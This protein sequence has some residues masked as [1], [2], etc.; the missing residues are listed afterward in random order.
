MNSS[1]FKKS[2]KHLYTDLYE[3]NGIRTIQFLFLSE[4]NHC[5]EI[6]ICN[7]VNISG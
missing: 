1:H 4:T 6:E 2:T 3:Y 5:N 7:V